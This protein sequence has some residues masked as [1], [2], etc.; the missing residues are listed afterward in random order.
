MH[1]AAQLHRS[2]DSVRTKAAELGLGAAV[3][4]QIAKRTRK[5]GID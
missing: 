1:V 2:P 5:P 4:Y 3:D